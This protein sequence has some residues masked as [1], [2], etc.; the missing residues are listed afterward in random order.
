MNNEQEWLS[1]IAQYHQNKGKTN[2]SIVLLPGYQPELCMM[3]CNHLEMES[4]D[5]RAE[6]MQAFGHQADSVDLSHLDNC[7]QTHSRSKGVFVHNVEALLCVK[8]KQERHQWLQSF[9]DADWQNPIYITIAVFQDDVPEEHP[10]VCDLELMRI[11]R[12]ALKT[13]ANNPGQL[14]YEAA[15]IKSRVY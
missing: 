3:L 2:G 13:A 4:F 10:H 14:K 8:T 12:E 7:L 9:L 6:E 11:P 15:G 5:Y 1:A